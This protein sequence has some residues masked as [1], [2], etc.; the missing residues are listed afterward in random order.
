M[1]NRDD[2]KDEEYSGRFSSDYE[3]EDAEF[4]AQ[5]DEEPRRGV[6]AFVIALGILVVVSTVIWNAYR[7]GVREGGR[8][9]PPRIT[10][11]G[12]AKVAPIDPGGATIPGQDV[13]IYDELDG[14]QTADSAPPAAESPRASGQVAA[15][16][17]P[18]VAPKPLAAAGGPAATPSAPAPLAS[19]NFAIV[20]NGPYL[21]Q[22]AALRSEEAANAEWAKASRLAPDLFAAAQK[23]IQRADLGAK[24]IFYRLRAGSFA[25]RDAADAFCD[26]V[27]ASGSGCIVAAR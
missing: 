25:S 10:A 11:E 23:D 16:A 18:A 15:L 8:D 26:Q 5:E 24:G 17:P 27:Q 20:R 22:I 14:A 19:G 12:P 13:A 21:A 7:S 6:L 3:E 9:A 4:D 1:K 2:D